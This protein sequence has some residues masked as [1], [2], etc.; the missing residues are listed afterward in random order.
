MINRIKHL[1]STLFGAGLILAGLYVGLQAQQWGVAS[2]LIVAGLYF[3]GYK[4]NG[5]NNES[6]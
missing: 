3:V 1:P 2:T 4:P 6:N 5:A